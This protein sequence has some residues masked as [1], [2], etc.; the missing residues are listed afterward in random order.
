MILFEY[1]YY[2]LKKTAIVE[3]YYTISYYDFPETYLK[4]RKLELLRRKFFWRYLIMHF[5]KLGINKKEFVY[6][7]CE[8][9]KNCKDMIR[10]IYEIQKRVPRPRYGGFPNPEIFYIL[11]RKIRP[12]IVIETGVSFGITSSFILQA[13]EEN[14][15]G[16]L[17][18]IDL[19]FQ[20]ATKEEVGMAVPKRLRHRWE[21]I[22]GDSK[23]ELPRL[24]KDLDII[25]VFFHDSLHTYEHMMFEFK[26]AWPKIKKGGY[27]ISDNIDE[28]NSFIDFC[29]AVKCKPIILSAN[30]GILVK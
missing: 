29:K 3:P 6:F 10:R 9:L 23:I 11:V 2:F 1:F 12:K 17:Y 18:S 15:F 24:L 22:L 27:L 28:N 30:L 25:D 16:T 26:T 7:Y 13:M 21:L 19:P 20:F 14:E 5:N 4:S 8:C